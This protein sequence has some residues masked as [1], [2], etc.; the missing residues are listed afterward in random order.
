MA[1]VAINSGANPIV[2]MHLTHSVLKIQIPEVRMYRTDYIGKIK[3]RL[4]D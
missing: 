2:K 1:A 3:V 4:P